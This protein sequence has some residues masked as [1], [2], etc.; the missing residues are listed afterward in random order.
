MGDPRMGGSLC[1]L[2]G[3]CAPPPQGPWVQIRAREMYPC[4]DVR[5]Y[6]REQPALPVTHPGRLSSGLQ[7]DASTP[8]P[9]NLGM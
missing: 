2:G 8:K 7:N 6:A 4:P 9:Q 3:L 1:G 5:G